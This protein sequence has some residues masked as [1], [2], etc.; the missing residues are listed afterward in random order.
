MTERHQ[1]ELLDNAIDSLNEALSK[2]Q[3]A[4]AGDVKA[5]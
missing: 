5:Y 1:L 3:Q 2:Y 4:K